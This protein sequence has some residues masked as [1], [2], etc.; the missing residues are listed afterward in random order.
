M[1]LSSSSC[2]FIVVATH[3]L[4]LGWACVFLDPCY[5]LELDVPAIPLSFFD[6]CYFSFFLRPVGERRDPTDFFPCMPANSEHAAT[7]PLFIDLA[8]AAGCTGLRELLCNTPSVTMAM[9][10]LCTNDCDHMWKKLK[11]KSIR[12][13]EAM[14]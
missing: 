4:G 12:T 14:F 8:A 6:P 9:A 11:E 7:Q 1:R 13:L 3:T 10:H 2:F 5:L